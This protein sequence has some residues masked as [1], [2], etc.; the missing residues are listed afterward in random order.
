MFA[1]APCDS[2]GAGDLARVST[3]VAGYAGEGSGLGRLGL[4]EVEEVSR[5]GALRGKL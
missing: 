4:F 2:T 5:M 1:E 3:F